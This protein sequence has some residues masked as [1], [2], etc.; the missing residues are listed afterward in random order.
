DQWHHREHIKAAYLYLC[1]YPFEAALP[2][3]RAKIQ[4]L[5]A[6]HKVPESV[7][8]GYHETMTVAWLRLVHSALCEYGP[9]ENADL[10]YDAHPELA[11]SKILRLFYSS[12]RLMSPEAKMAFV[13]P[14]LAPLPQPRKENVKIQIP[15]PGKFRAEIQPNRQA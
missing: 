5:N 8:R 15:N 1:R 13:E 14:D 2:R 7:K 4:A 12:E 11:Q 3:L 9:A 10:F 6:V